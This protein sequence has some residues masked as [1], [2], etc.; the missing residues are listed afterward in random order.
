MFGVDK[1]FKTK[2]V[3]HCVTLRIPITITA[4]FI[5]TFFWA[6][7]IQ[8]TS[9]AGKS[10]AVRE[11]HYSADEVRDLYHS[12]GVPVGEDTYSGPS[13]CEIG[14]PVPFHAF[15]IPPSVVRERAFS[16]DWVV[17]RTMDPPHNGQEL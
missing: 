13:A 14:Y 7:R 9:L 11:L 12:C 2:D 1:G 15:F 17:A 6:C 4:P 16:Q 3:L 5:N 10:I 8:S